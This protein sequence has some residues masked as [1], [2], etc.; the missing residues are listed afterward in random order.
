M[1][2]REEGKECA[3]TLQEEGRGLMHTVKKWKKELNRCRE[4]AGDGES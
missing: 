2:K 4:D 3:I 1:Q